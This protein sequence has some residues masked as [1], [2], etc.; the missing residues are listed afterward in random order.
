[1][2][3]VDVLALWGWLAVISVVT[4]STV[5]Y[6]SLKGRLGDDALAM[7]QRTAARAD[8]CAGGS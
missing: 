6:R 2:I 5:M 8:G 1:M 3:C 7:T 4:D